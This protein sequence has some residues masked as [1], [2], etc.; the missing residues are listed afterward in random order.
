MAE[1]AQLELLNHKLQLQQVEAALELDKENEDLLKLKNDLEEVIKLTIELIGKPESS[2]VKWNVGDMC[3]AMCSRDK[4]EYDTTDVC[5]VSLAFCLSTVSFVLTIYGPQCSRPQHKEEL[6]PLLGSIMLSLEL[7]LSPEATLRRCSSSA[8]NKHRAVEKKKMKKMKVS[9]RRE[10][11][12][13]ACEREKNQWLN[14]NKKMV[15]T[16]KIRKSIFASPETIDGRVG[17]GTCGIAG[18]PMTKFN[19]HARNVRK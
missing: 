4:L 9:Q 17:I 12:E 2:E 19:T 8:E 3:M 16:G 11:L 5:Q 6:A 14:F 18:R 10:E 13:K 15:K 7:N 1:E